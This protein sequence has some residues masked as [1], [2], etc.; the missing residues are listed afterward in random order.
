MNTLVRKGTLFGPTVEM[1][2]LSEEC[3]AL[4]GAIPPGVCVPLHPHNDF[5][6]AAQ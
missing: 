3:C 4:L 2:C 1:L 6:G 5:E